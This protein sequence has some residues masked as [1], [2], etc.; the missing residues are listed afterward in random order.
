MHTTTFTHDDNA[1]ITVNIPLK[2]GEEDTIHVFHFYSSGV[3]DAKKKSF[4]CRVMMMITHTHSL[5][6]KS[7]RCYDGSNRC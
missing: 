6:N 3:I 7:I 4:R 1:N 2:K 5:D